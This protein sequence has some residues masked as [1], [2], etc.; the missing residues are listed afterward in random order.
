MK[1]IQKAF[2]SNLEFVKQKEQSISNRQNQEGSF[3][4]SLCASFEVLILNEIISKVKV[5][6][7]VLMFDGFLFYGDRPTDFL[8]T[9]NALGKNVGFDMEWSYKEHDTLLNVPDDYETNDPDVLYG[10]TKDKYE[11]DYKMAFIDT[12]NNISYKIDGVVH[13]FS[14]TDM[15]FK[16]DDVRIKD[17]PFFPRWSKDP[18]KQRFNCVGVYPH[19]TIC[20]DS[21]LNLWNGY[22]VEKIQPENEVVNE[23]VNEVVADPDLFMNHLKIICKESVVLEFLLDWLANMFQYPSNQSI[24]VVIQGEEGS[25][26]SVI[27]DFVTKILGCGYCLEINSVEHALFGR[28]NAQLVN[29]VFVNINEIDRT[30]MSSY[31]E[32]LKA[33]ITQPTLTIEDKGKKRFEV[34]NLL[35]FMTTCNNENAFKITE[36]SRRFMY[37]ETSNELIGNTDYFTALFHYIEQPQNQRRFYD[38]MMNRPVKKQI[39]VKDIPITDDMRK[40]FEFNRDPIEDYARDFTFKLTAMENYDTYKSYLLANGLKFEKPKKAFEM[41]FAKYMEK[42]EIYKKD[43]MVEGNRGRYYIKKGYEKPPTDV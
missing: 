5:E 41:A 13:Y 3:M 35:H 7:G 34:N 19:D 23:A 21:V 38:L 22:D 30:T 17:D 15:L 33:I 28:F 24:M 40:Q 25:G 43:L 42:N 16:L 12:T 36:T 6:I 2:I 18:T 29:K 39:T 9:L 37:L 32:Q 8:E 1:T 31:G 4:S 27:C 11:R 14:K 26:K 10:L 20:P